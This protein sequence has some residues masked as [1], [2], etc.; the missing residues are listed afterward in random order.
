MQDRGKQVAGVKNL[1]Q[2]GLHA[3]RQDSHDQVHRKTHPKAR[4]W[5]TETWADTWEPGAWPDI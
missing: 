1:L 3:G 2:N 5:G 4:T